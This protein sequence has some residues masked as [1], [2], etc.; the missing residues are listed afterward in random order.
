MQVL[1][2]YFP[3]ILSSKR[4]WFPSLN[5]FKTTSDHGRRLCDGFEEKVEELI[6]DGK[7]E[8][9]ANQPIRHNFSV[10]KKARLLHNLV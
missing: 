3:K 2:W 1:F 5:G 10:P 7:S 6:K 4:L 9:E 8:K